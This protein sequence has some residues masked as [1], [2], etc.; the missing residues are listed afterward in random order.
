MGFCNNDRRE[1]LAFAR[2]GDT[3]KSRDG[4]RDQSCPPR[5]VVMSLKQ[6]IETYR[7][8]LPELLANEGKY[9]V[10]H[11]DE[12]AGICETHADALAIGY[13]RYGD[14]PFLVRQ[15]REKEPILVL[16]RSLRPCLTPPPPSV[17][18]EQ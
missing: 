12:I 5:G 10:I 9:V 4:M 1:I 14:Q 17:Q 8:K 13:E 3:I 6:E 16:T 7:R 11:G 18:T 2:P 15:I